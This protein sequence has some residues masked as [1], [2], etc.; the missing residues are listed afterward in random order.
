MRRAERPGPGQE[1]QAE[2]KNQNK[3]EVKEMELK[4]LTLET[5]KADRSD[6]VDAIQKEGNDAGVKLERKRVLDIQEAVKPFEGMNELANEAIKSGATVEEA[7]SK[8]KDQR[9]VDL[10]KHAP[11]SQGPADDPEKDGGTELSLEDQCKKD[12][13]KD[14]KI[15][16]EFKTEGAYL[17]YKKAE[18][19]GAVKIL[20]K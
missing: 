7:V 11:K 2:S 16:D 19:R 20:K 8:F 1:K 17:A 13:E 18:A 3:E 9:I 15:R 14:S 10:E 5:L 4:E 12:W 6:L